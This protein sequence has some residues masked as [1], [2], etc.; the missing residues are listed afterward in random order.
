[1][2]KFDIERFMPSNANDPRYVII[3][4]HLLIEKI[5][6]KFVHSHLSRPEMLNGKEINFRQLVAFAQAMQEKDLVMPWMYKAMKR[7]ALLR[8]L[9]A[10]NLT[11]IDGEMQIKKFINLV[12]DN[13]KLENVAISGEYSMLASAIINLCLLLSGALKIN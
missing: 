1:M 9:Y 12:S 5:F 10:H 4:G 2:T 8:D 6:E 11:P 3:S 13:R 7:L